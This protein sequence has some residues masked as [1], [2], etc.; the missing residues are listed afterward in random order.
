VLGKTAAVL[1]VAQLS[2]WCRQRVER[3][4]EVSYYQI[5]RE[6]LCDCLE[7]KHESD[8]RYRPFRCSFGPKMREPA[9]EYNSCMVNTTYLY[10]RY[11][12]LG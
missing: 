7:E 2:P 4:I 12:R 1:G 6:V 8:L 9:V 10:L 11:V 5:Q 3:Q